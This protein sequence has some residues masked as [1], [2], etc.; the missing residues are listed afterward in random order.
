MGQIGHVI[1]HEEPFIDLLADENQ[2]HQNHRNGDLALPDIREGNQ[3][4][5]GKDHAA[6]P[7]EGNRREKDKIDDPRYERRDADDLEDLCTAVFLFQHRPEKQDIGH[8]PDKMRPAVMP[9]HMGEKPDI[10]QRIRQ[11]RAIG[12][13][14]QPA[15]FAAGKEAEDQNGK[16]GKGK[17]QH[18]RSVICDLQFFHSFYSLFISLSA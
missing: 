2:R 9:E 1:L 6:G 15:A 18:N 13:E 3:Q 7:A 4:D 8:V 11:G 5:K 17:A 10:G 16:T 14:K 12:H